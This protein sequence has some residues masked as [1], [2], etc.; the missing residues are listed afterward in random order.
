MGRGGAPGQACLE[1]EGQ[2]STSR[3]DTNLRSS[4][5]SQDWGRLILGAA[6]VEVSRASLVPGIS[7]YRQEPHVLSTHTSFRKLD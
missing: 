5:E 2:I 1:L 3:A 7:S 4:F 6:K